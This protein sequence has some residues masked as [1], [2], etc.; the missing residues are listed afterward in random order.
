MWLEGLFHFFV[1]VA[2]IIPSRVLQ[3][4]YFEF[5]NSFEKNHLLIFEQGIVAALMHFAAATNTTS[6]LY[7]TG[8]KYH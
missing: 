6:I 1:A 5:R 8:G 2:V 7:Q 3:F 4:C